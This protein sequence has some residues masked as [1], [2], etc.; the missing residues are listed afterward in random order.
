[1]NILA[2]PKSH[3]P[4]GF[5]SIVPYIHVDGAAAFLEFI[6]KAFGAKETFRSNTPEG[7]IMHAAARIGD[8]MIEVS[9]ATDQW[10]AMPCAIHLYLPD[11]DGAYRSALAAGATSLY[12]PADMFYGERSAGV[13]DPFGNKWYIATHVEDISAEEMEARQRAHMQKQAQQMQQ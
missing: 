7:K 3:V 2:K 12:E 9:D 8:A 5:Q 4:E 10:Q 13:A 6:T 11:P 1:V